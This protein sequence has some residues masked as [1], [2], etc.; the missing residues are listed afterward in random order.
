MGAQPK[1]ADGVTIDRTTTR[2]NLGILA[3][4]V[5]S[6]IFGTSYLKDIEHAV[7]LANTTLM[8]VK[9]QLNRQNGRTDQHSQQFLEHEARLDALDKVQAIHAARVKALEDGK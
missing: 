6:F 3:S 5:V 4:V 9:A 2:V 8:E 7:D 1:P